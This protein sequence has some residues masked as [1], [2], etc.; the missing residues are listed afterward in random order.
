VQAEDDGPQ[1]VVVLLRVVL[2]KDPGRR[3]Q[4]PTALLKVIPVITGAIDVQR[5]ITRQ[6][7]QKML[8]TASRERLYR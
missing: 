5:R 2:E 1:P 4:K 7:L 3:F 8:P 6:G